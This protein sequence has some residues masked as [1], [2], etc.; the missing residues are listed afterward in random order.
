[1]LMY[2]WD[3]FPAG[4]CGV[5]GSRE[6]ATARAEEALLG[7]P[8]VIAVLVAEVRAVMSP[9]TSHHAPTGLTWTGIR[10]GGAVA[11]TAARAPGRELDRLAG[12]MALAGV[13]P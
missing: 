3:T 10:A 2:T 13:M 7:R 1:M 11:W 6:R 9:F 5:S 8:V 4:E 12:L